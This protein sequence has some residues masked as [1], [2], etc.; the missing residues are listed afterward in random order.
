MTQALSHL[1][2]AFRLR[3]GINWL[4]MA[5]AYA[6][7]YFG[8]YNL[9]VAKS[10]F[11]DTGMTKAQ[12][13]DIFM[14]GSVV[15]GFSF[16]VTGPLVDKIGGRAG[17]LIGVFG[18]MMANLL[19]G[20]VVYGQ[21]MWGWE[22]PVIQVIGLLYCVNMHFQSY[23]AISIVT[24]K[25]PWFH[26]KERGN[27]STIFGW[28]IATGIYFAFDLGGAVVAATRKEIKGEL[29]WFGDFVRV[30]FGT[31]GSGVDQNWWVFFLP[32]IFMG[33]FW[34]MMYLWLKNTPAEAGYQNFNTGEATLTESGQ[35]EPVRSVF[36]KILKHP[37]L[38]IVCIVEFF[39]GILRNGIMHWYTFFA[40]ATGQGGFWIMKNWG[41]CLL[42]CGIVGSWLT[43]QISD[44]Y[45]NSRRAPMAVILYAI[46][47]V[48]ACTMVFAI[49]K[50][51]L[52]FG[53]G[54]LAISMAVTGVHGIFSG[55][56]TADFAGTRNAGAA[57]AIVDG[58]VYLGSAFQSGVL[59][60]LT[61][62][63]D[64]A[65][66][67]ANWIN[68]PIFLIPAALIGIVLAASIWNAHPASARKH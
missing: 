31:G 3:R 5:L 52:V 22:L 16:L 26:V 35:R 13:G 59:G 60:R 57:V 1:T 21:Q 2:R 58:A 65:K 48:S 66:D 34:V 23:G 12:F 10:A 61:P 67:P 25:A 14:W 33:T 53:L 51:P 6:S 46:M 40:P 11:G 9:T 64:A 39:S 28:I 54:A 37:V 50:G 63:G 49:D 56:A 43:G 15:Y 27:F 4:P 44:R 19:M 29:H 36:I 20:V 47:L 55:T 41:L 30:V 7:L 45:F 8:R 42:V 17:M 62:S 18:A 68:W 32:S 38:Q 24:T